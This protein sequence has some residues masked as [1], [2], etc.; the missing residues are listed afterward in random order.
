M[1][2]SHSGARRA[3]TLIELLVVIAII[4]ILAAILF[5]VF[6]RAREN[7]RKTSCLSNLKQIGL[8][9]QQYMQ[10]NDSAYPL[11]A[12]TASNGGKLRWADAIQTYTKSRQLFLCPSASEKLRS[13]TWFDGAAGVYGGYG[14]NYQYLGNGRPTVLFSANDSQITAPSQTVAVADTQGADFENRPGAEGSYTIDPPLTSGRGSGKASGFYADGAQCGGVNGCRST[15]ASHHLELGNYLFADGH[16]KAMR[17]SQIDDFDGN[18][19]KDNGFW[20]GR[21]DALSN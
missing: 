21:A 17:L 13:K 7:A 15:P 18:G 12:Y 2:T 20:N 19:A 4:S 8:G 11:A 6:G 9:L 5:P 10:D 14:Y 16:A 3:F 1:N